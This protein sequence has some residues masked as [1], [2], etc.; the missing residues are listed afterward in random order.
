MTKAVALL[1][2]AA[3]IATAIP[4]QAGGLSSKLLLSSA[5]CTYSYNKITG[6]SN[7]SRLRFSA[8]GTYSSGSRSEG[9]SSGPSGSIASQGDSGG[10]GRWKVVAGEL[11]MS[12]GYGQLELVQTFV[13]NNSN[14]YPVIVGDGVEYSQCR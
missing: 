8:D 14:G 9:Y 13:K 10:D 3:S 5:W 12:E 1:V 2:I 4:V 7:S 11:Y 6:Y